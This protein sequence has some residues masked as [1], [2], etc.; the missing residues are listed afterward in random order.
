MCVSRGHR[1]SDEPRV[2]PPRQPGVPRAT[3]TPPAP[4]GPP[5]RPPP[6]PRTGGSPPPPPPRQPPR[7]PS[8]PGFFLPAPFVLLRGVGGPLFLRKTQKPR[9]NEEPADEDPE[10]DE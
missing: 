3:S 7:S 1:P 8:E 2:S 4:G 10:E 9:K 6:T 5:P